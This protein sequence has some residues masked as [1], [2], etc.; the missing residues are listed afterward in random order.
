M[1]AKQWR[2]MSTLPESLDRMYATCE[3]GA[4]DTTP[5]FNEHLYCVHCG[6][7]VTSA[8]L[9]VNGQSACRDAVLDRAGKVHIPA[10][11]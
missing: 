9:D 11:L 2:G 8:G 10:P 5:D 1:N 3:D 7:N 6:T 4:M